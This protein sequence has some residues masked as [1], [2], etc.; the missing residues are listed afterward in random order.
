MALLEMH[1]VDVFYGSVQ[2][3]RGVSLQVEAGERVA[4]LGANG[5]GKTTTLRTI[6]GL[7]APRRGSISFDGEEIGGLPAHEVV[8][9][10][11]AHGPEGRALFPGL[12]VEENLRFGWLPLRAQKGT[13]EPALE[14]AFAH[15]P[16]LKERRKQAAGTMSGGEQQM[17]VVARALMSSPRLLIVDELSLGLAP[18][19]VSLLFDIIREVNAEGTAVLIVEQFVHT[20]LANTDR[21]YV[22]T[23]GEVVLEGRSSDL[24]GSDELL[25]SYLGGEVDPEQ[26]AAGQAHGDAGDPGRRRRSRTT[27]KP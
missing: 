11:V 14:R 1:D 16:R 18:K 10:G 7:L 23:K 2:A 12:S 5:A 15:F 8:G 27:T 20:A 21:A 25:A 4:L 3:L 24:L 26:G 22:L 17:L 6:S 9:K 13:F 19:I